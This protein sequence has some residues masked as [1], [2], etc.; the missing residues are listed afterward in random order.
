MDRITFVYRGILIL[1]YLR[2]E[3]LMLVT[4]KIAVFWD[5]M[6]SSLVD[7]YQHA[8]AMCYLYFR[9]EE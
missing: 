2:F 9:I 5:V 7:L 3:V 8:G 4:V 6:L 1:D